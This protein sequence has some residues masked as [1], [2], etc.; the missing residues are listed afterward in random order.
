VR[1]VLGDAAAAL[2]A[3]PDASADC[4][5][6]SPP[7]WG[8]RDYQ[9]TGQYG[10]EP[11]LEAYVASLTG[12]FDQLRRVLAPTGTLWLNL[13]DTYGGSWANYIAAGSN[14]RTAQQRATWPQ[15]NTRPPQ[16][17][18]RPKDLQAVPWRVALALAQRGWKLRAGYVWAKPNARPESVRDRLAQ[19]YEMLFLL[20]LRHSHWWAPGPGPEQ[21]AQVWSIPTP[22][23]NTGHIA[24]GPVQLARRALAYGCP[25]AGRVLD[26]FCGSGTTGVAAHALGHTF[27]GIDLDPGRPRDRPHPTHPDMPQPMNDLETT[28]L[29]RTRVLTLAQVAALPA[30]VDLPTAARALG[31]GRTTAYLLAKHNQFPCPVVKLAHTYRVPTAGLL[32]LLGI[33]TPNPA[34]AEH[35]EQ[36]SPRR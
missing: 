13:A 27:T 16:A 15:G 25:P 26:P 19:R 24:A 11:T 10:L 35:H 30:I 4:V 9:V 6:T 2:A 17:R 32:H 20:T 33:T 1:L 14:S 7:Y 12:V 8:L 5:V 21:I 3:L 36:P 29:G 31:I 18:S 23:A 22:R 34:D 28:E